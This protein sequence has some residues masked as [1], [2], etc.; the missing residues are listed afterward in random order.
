MKKVKKGERAEGAARDEESVVI[1][2]PVE[3]PT[4]DFHSTDQS[5]N[6]A[7]EKDDLHRRN[8]I[9]LFDENVHARE[10]ESGHEHVGHATAEQGRTG[11]SRLMHP[12]SWMQAVVGTR[13]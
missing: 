2:F 9:E 11:L 5:G 13:S 6:E 1:A 10:G 4:R 7:T 12:A 3:L 8:A